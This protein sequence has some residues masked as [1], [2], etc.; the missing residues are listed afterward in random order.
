MTKHFGGLTALAGVDIAVEAGEIV[1]LIG[2]NGSGKTTLFHCIAGALTPDSG[3]IRLRGRSVVGLLP[4]AM[5]ARGVG[6]TFQL[7][8]IFPQLSALES[9]RPSENPEPPAHGA[10]HPRG[11]DRGASTPSIATVTRLLAGS[12]RRCGIP[13]GIPGQR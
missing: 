7:V 6:R 13:Y 3:D 12:V 10:R 5:C 11:E 2:P 9:F 4:H 8:R 1:G